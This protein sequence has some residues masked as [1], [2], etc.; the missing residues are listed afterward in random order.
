RPLT[1]TGSN[2]TFLINNDPTH[3]GYAQ[4]RTA[5]AGYFAA[6]GIPLLRGRLFAA[7]DHAD[8]PPVAVVSQSLAQQYWPHEDPI[9]KQI[10]FGNMD[11]DK[12]LLQIVGVVGDVRERGLDAALA[13]TV[14][15]N[16]PQRPQASA[17]SIVVRTENDP[18]TLTA[19]LRQ[20]V[21]ALDPEL[22]MSFRTLKQIY[23][24]SLDVRRFSLV[25]FGIFAAVALLLAALG[26]YGVVAYTVT[27]RTHEIGIRMALGAQAA[28]IF[29]L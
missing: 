10:Q 29:K 3:T 27:Q 12:R 28:D 1:G 2:G 22:P 8:A 19:A 14:Y 18:T 5:S 9:G 7:S 26:L 15:A 25:V 17:L 16:A 20:A 11:G 13:G 24:A 23:S 6:M 4:Y 21:Q